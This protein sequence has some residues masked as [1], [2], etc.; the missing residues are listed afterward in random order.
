MLFGVRDYVGIMEKK[1]EATI[2]DY[3]GDNGKEHGKYYV[4]FKVLG[5]DCRATSS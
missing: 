5:S 2:M 3:I 1:V 4:G